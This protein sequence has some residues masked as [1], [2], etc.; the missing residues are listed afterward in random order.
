M[1]GGRQMAHVFLN[2]GG[3]E[4]EGYHSNYYYFDSS[5]C[6][7]VSGIIKAMAG[8]NPSDP[9][10]RSQVVKICKAS[11]KAKQ[12]SRVK[13]KRP[14]SLPKRVFHYILQCILRV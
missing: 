3:P 11:L 13:E 12:K 5:D 6:H 8:K 14:N 9:H 2:D 10:E 7:A 4:A 1:S